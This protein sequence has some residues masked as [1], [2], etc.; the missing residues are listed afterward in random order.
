MSGCS[1]LLP[2]AVDTLSSSGGFVFTDGVV[3]DVV[4]IV[5][6]LLLP[7]NSGKLLLGPML[8]VDWF[9]IVRRVGERLPG[10]AL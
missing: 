2:A 8:L 1:L 6:L 10:F 5:L 4:V 7:M 3:D 9:V